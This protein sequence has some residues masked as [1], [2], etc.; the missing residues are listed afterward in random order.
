MFLCGWDDNQKDN[1]YKKPV[2]ESKT[3]KHNWEEVSRSKKMDRRA[4][5][6]VK[7][8]AERKYFE[9]FKASLWCLEDSM[10]ILKNSHSDFFWKITF[11]KNSKKLS[12]RDQYY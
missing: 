10:E 6:Y 11:L 9:D 7:N 5:Y 1:F 8:W 3:G 12:E 2:E 4:I